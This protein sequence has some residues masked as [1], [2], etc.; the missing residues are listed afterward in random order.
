MVKAGR[1]QRQAGQHNSKHG[2]ARDA[3]AVTMPWPCVWRWA[4][5]LVTI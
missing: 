5:A 4:Q 2:N 1:G 3:G